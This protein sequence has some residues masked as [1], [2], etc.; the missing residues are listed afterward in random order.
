MARAQMMSECTKLNQTFLTESSKTL[1]Q[2]KEILMN[3]KLPSS[4][5]QGII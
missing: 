3:D 4:F 5:I 1:L 2:F